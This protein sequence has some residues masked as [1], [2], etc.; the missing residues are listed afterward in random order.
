MFKAVS[1][2]Y[3]ILSDPEKRDLYDKLGR[4]GVSGGGEDPFVMFKMMFG[5]GKFNDNFG[6]LGFIKAMLDQMGMEGEEVDQE[7]M[8]ARYQKESE[9]QENLLIRKLMIKLEPG[10][11]NSPL[12]RKMIEADLSDKVEAPGGPA[13]LVIIGDI[14]VEKGKQHMGRFLGM[15]GFFSGIAEKGH[16]VGQV[17]DTIS[18]TMKLMKEMEKAQVSGGEM[19]EAHVAKMGLNVFWCFGKLEISRIVSTVCEAV[20]TEPGLPESKLKKRAEALFVMGEMYMAAG[21]K[22]QSTNPVKDSK[23]LPAHLADVLKATSQNRP[24][25]TQDDASGNAGIA[26]YA[27][28]D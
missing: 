2:A 15:E 28:H 17:F 3:T 27:H 5:L 20:L 11:S 25:P 26:T 12:F 1:E 21:R 6:E 16:F 23:E 9:I 18:V 24:N 7:A 22:A 13:L 4:A 19:D 14:Y 8:Q 10:V